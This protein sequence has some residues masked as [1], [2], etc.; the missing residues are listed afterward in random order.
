MDGGDVRMV[1]RGEQPR[2]ALEA[3]HALGVVGYGLGQ[4]LD[5]DVAAAGRVGRATPRTS[6]SATMRLEE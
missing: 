2:F 5:G 6:R 4:H 1:E 3:R